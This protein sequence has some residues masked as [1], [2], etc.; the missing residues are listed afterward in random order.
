MKKRGR[1]EKA[2]AEKRWQRLDVRVSQAEK[3]A[4]RLAAESAKQDLSV[5]IRVQ[6]HRA[7][8]ED[9]AEEHGVDDHGD[10]RTAQTDAHCPGRV[11]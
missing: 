4:F 8:S 7:A 5:W 9:R 6:L 10:K 1:P 11:R 3:Q 2:P